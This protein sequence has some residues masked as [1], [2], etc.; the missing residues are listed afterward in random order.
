MAARRM[1]SYNYCRIQP[2]IVR[3]SS[4]RPG[5][6]AHTLEKSAYLGMSQLA[7]STQTAVR[8]HATGSNKGVTFYLFQ[9][10]NFQIKLVFIL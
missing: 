9:R 5:L 3:M 10:R 2:Y 7:K 6:R 4:I 8:R 1:S